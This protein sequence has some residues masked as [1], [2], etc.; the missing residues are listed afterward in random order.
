MAT[1]VS[2]AAVARAVHQATGDNVGL[3]KINGYY[4]WVPLDTGARELLQQV[5][6]F[7][8]YQKVTDLS[9]DG[10]VKEYKRQTGRS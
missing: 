9:L 5:G 4:H 6:T 7:T 8:F 3:R 2:P 1:R 10:W